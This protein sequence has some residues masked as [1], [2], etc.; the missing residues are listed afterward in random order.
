MDLFV[1]PLTSARTAG[2]SSHEQTSRRPSLARSR[3][4][5]DIFWQEELAFFNPAN[6][7]RAS[8]AWV[9][10]SYSFVPTNAKR[11]NKMLKVLPYWSILN[12]V[13]KIC[14]PNIFLEL[15]IFD[16]LKWFSE[17]IGA[18]HH[19]ICLASGRYTSWDKD[20]VQTSASQFCNIGFHHLKQAC[21]HACAKS[22]ADLQ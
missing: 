12:V 7:I 2:L 14:A 13:L 17:Y 11:R 21:L 8:L 10:R 9:W 5:E 3:T 15:F 22:D 19:I 20:E 1:T 4:V 18:Q 6:Y 16:L